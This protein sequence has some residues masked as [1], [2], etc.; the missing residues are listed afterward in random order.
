[1]GPQT[2]DDGNVCQFIDS[3]FQ[4]EFGTEEERW[5]FFSFIDYYLKRC[6][7]KEN[8][9]ST[10][11]RIFEVCRKHGY[12][13]Q[14]N[15]SGWPSTFISDVRLSGD[16]KFVIIPNARS[17]MILFSGELIPY[18]LFFNHG[19]ENTD[20]S[21]NG[22]CLVNHYRYEDG[23]RIEAWDTEKFRILFESDS[24]INKVWWTGPK[25][26]YF[27]NGENKLMRY[28]GSSV[29]EDT[30]I[31]LGD[32]VFSFAVDEANGLLLSLDPYVNIMDMKTEATYWFGEE[33]SEDSEIYIGKDGFRVFSNGTLY[34]IGGGMKVLF[35]SS[36]SCISR[37]LHPERH[38][39]AT[40]GFGKDCRGIYAMVEK[41][42]F[43]LG[44]KG[45]KSVASY[46]TVSEL[47]LEATHL[48]EGFRNEELFILE[49]LDQG[50]R[51]RYVYDKL[52]AMET[53][54]ITNGQGD[55]LILRPLGM[56]S[57][58]VPKAEVFI[59]KSPPFIWDCQQIKGKLNTSTSDVHVLDTDLIDLFALGN[60]SNGEFEMGMRHLG[61][62]ILT[63]TTS[64]S[65]FAPIARLLASAGVKWNPKFHVSYEDE[66]FSLCFSV[67][68]SAGYLTL[69]I[70]DSGEVDC[71]EGKIIDTYGHTISQKPVVFSDQGWFA[72]GAYGNC[73]KLKGV[74]VNAHDVLCT[75]K[76]VLWQSGG[77][78]YS[79]RKP[80]PGL[81]V[82]TDNQLALVSENCVV[83][84]GYES[85]K[86]VRLDEDKSRTFSIYECSH[87]NVLGLSDTGYLSM[88]H[89]ER[90]NTRII[91]DFAE[92][93]MNTGRWNNLD[94][95]MDFEV[96]ISE[97]IGISDARIWGSIFN[98]LDLRKQRILRIDPNPDRPII[99]RCDLTKGT[100]RSNRNGFRANY[101]K[102]SVM[103]I[104]L[105]DGMYLIATTELDEN[106]K[107]GKDKQEDDNKPSS[108]ISVSLRPELRIMDSTAGLKYTAGGRYNGIM[109]G[110]K[111]YYLRAK[112]K[113]LMLSP[114]KDFV[115]VTYD[116]P[117]IAV[118]SFDVKT[119]R[120]YPDKPVRGMI[121]GFPEKERILI[122]LTGPANVVEQCQ[123][124]DYRL[125]P[126]GPVQTMDFPTKDLFELN[127]YELPH[128]ADG[129]GNHWCSSE[130][131]SR[132]Q[133]SGDL[134]SINESEEGKSEVDVELV[135][136]H[137]GM[138]RNRV[139]WHTSF[140]PEYGGP[141]MMEIKENV[142]KTVK[143]FG[144]ESITAVFDMSGIAEKSRDG[145][146]D[147]MIIRGDRKK[148]I[149]IQSPF[150]VDGYYRADCC[151]IH[152][153]GDAYTYSAQDEGCTL[154]RRSRFTEDGEVIDLNSLR[155]SDDYHYVP[156]FADDNLLILRRENGK[157]FF[158]DDWMNIREV[159][160]DASVSYLLYGNLFLT[161]KDGGRYRFISEGGESIFSDGRLS[162]VERSRKDHSAL[163]ISTGTLE[164]KE[165]I[166]TLRLRI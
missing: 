44:E 145:V 84:N 33:M 12:V 50:E 1:M 142:K 86:T 106:G 45:V 36:D 49:N 80:V 151:P 113:S 72:I 128:G 121:L 150:Y 11:D 17:T 53:V 148:Q 123:V 105:N 2:F 108:R 101:T 112:D 21:P 59:F 14:Y 136:V 8:S 71:I 81:N 92:L 15:V 65:S 90:E 32:A 116:S 34:R 109:Y 147:A 77:V 140:V 63:C 79:R 39:A 96:P 99:K 146:Y 149:S 144:S 137:L 132:L 119:Q 143:F 6:S 60:P 165:G 122:G 141:T 129:D 75:G 46:P 57:P 85:L 67:Q 31:S 35:E 25:S 155:I 124:F 73:T 95:R 111:G 69:I 161:E 127:R 110:P 152:V 98:Y 162:S 29:P 23:S 54:A 82:K 131:F 164:W 83:V 43:Y 70:N 94:G 7:S 114:D 13:P 118:N 3:R 133:K 166:F 153:L 74:G 55:I 100:I 138:I 126:I 28:G 9:S 139:L 10:V 120:T 62:E 66:C 104:E 125:N 42:R 41:T 19:A 78:W 51:R 115:F 76:T 64:V 91:A 16:S 56:V 37:S 4:E 156:L 18:A 24:A 30:G 134:F 103:P 5:T 130:H 47:P 160:L 107:T 159:E 52:R 154:I 20:L 38:Y 93:N 22:E 87:W 97:G 58:D 135:H 48:L 27:V 88:V 89:L 61:L 26:F 158:S 102:K 40:S 157:L 163:R 117:E 68:T